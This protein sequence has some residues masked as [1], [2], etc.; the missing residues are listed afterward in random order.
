MDGMVSRDNED[1]LNNSKVE[2][3]AKG[4]IQSH[5]F[6]PFEIETTGTATSKYIEAYAIFTRGTSSK[7][8]VYAVTV[9]DPETN[10][11]IVKVELADINGVVGTFINVEDKYSSLVF[12]DKND[13]K[14]AEYDKYS[15]E[16]NWEIKYSDNTGETIF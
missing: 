15:T 14:L 16:N 12:I 2:F 11:R 13:L 7:L 5:G 9:N 1:G 6:Q 4:S 10:K 8:G 3:N